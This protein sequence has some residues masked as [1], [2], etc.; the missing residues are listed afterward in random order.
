[1]NIKIFLLFARLTFA[2]LFDKPGDVGN[3]KEVPDDVLEKIWLPMPYIIHETAVLGEVETDDYV[4]VQVCADDGLDVDLSND[5]G[6][7]L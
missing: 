6:L 4:R 1:M 2:N 5:F 7:G 3:V